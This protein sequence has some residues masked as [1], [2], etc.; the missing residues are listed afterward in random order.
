MCN[1][2]MFICKEQ[3]SFPN[4]IFIALF[5]HMYLHSLFC[6]SSPPIGLY[7]FYLLIETSGSNAE[8]DEEKLN[9]YLEKYLSNGIVLDG[10]VTN[11]PG[12]IKVN[13]GT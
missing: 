1:S 9:K 6:Y 3:K 4:K 8:H 7:P 5:L 12:K 11:E 13:L 2:I 10:T